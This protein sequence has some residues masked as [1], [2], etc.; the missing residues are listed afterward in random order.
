MKELINKAAFPITDIWESNCQYPDIAITD[1]KEAHIS[2]QQYKNGHDFVYASKVENNEAVEPFM[3]SRKGLALR[4][5]NYYFNGAVWFIWSE[6]V[7]REWSILARYLKDGRYSDIIIVDTSEAAFYPSVCDDSEKLIVMWSEQSKGK[8]TTVLKYIDFGS[9]SE[10]E[11]VSVSQKTY[12]PSGCI[13]GD[14]NLYIAYD[15]F[16]GK[17]Y[18]LVVRVKH[19]GKW[20][21]E[22]KINASEDWA[23]SSAVIPSEDGITVGWYDIGPKAA[24]GYLTSDVSLDN[25]AL[26]ST[27]PDRFA[28]GVNWYQNVCMANNKRGISVFAYTWGKYNIHVRYRKGAGSWSKPVVM[29]YND[30]HCAVHPKIA[31]DDNNT[32]HLVWQFGNKNGHLRRNA[33]VIYNKLT[34]E[35][36]DKYI[37]EDA[38]LV[39]DKFVKPIP[40]E[41]RFDKNEEADV[42]KWM[43]RNGYSG[44]KLVFGD[45]HGQSSISDGVGEIDQYYHYAKVGADLDFTAL[46]DHDCYPDWISESEWEWMRTVNRLT[47]TDGELSTLLAYEWTPNEYRYDYGHKNVYYRGDEGEMFRSEDEGGMTPFKLFESLKKYKAMAIPHHPAADWGLVSA[48]TDWNFHDPEIQRLVEIFSR[49]AP[50]EYYGNTSK[51][52]KN[53]S[54]LKRCSVQ[55]ALGRRYRLGFTAGSDSHQL[56][57]GIEGGIVAAFV[58]ELTRENVFDALY[59][60]FVYAT[61]GARILVSLK[62]NGKRMGEEIS[63][64]ENEPVEVDVSVL[65]TDKFILELIKNNQVIKIENS[66]SNACDLR[67]TDYDR[68]SEDYYYVRVTQVDEHMAWSSPIWVELIK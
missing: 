42:L 65:G 45:I 15:V 12:R 23:A 30:G 27:K 8:S 47:N 46:T 24:F 33:S 39:E 32:V 67:Y 62:I 31:I 22:K 5:I 20:S 36:I 19:N 50:F 13:G 4:P 10:K 40:A 41:K 17:G 16:N 54:Q 9:M 11:T 21:D 56:E 52:T 1:G 7:N 38:E 28:S 18:D 6:C 61:T 3:I 60:R 26:T 58:P 25:G 44:L 59:Q 66:D 35:E 49:H 43:E 37:D 48:A 53:I 51:Y 29:S 14:G 55:D 34:L 57:H 2:W 64:N 68:S 63:V